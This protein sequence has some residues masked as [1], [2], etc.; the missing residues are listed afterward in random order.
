[1]EALV[2]H[3]QYYYNPWLLSVLYGRLFFQDQLMT[4]YQWLNPQYKVD[5]SLLL[6]ETR[7][8]QLIDELC[9]LQQSLQE[10]LYPFDWGQLNFEYVV[11][12]LATLFRPSDLY[13]H[14]HCGDVGQLYACE[15]VL[16]LS[17]PNQSESQLVFDAII[18]Y[19]KLYHLPGSMS[20]SGRL[21]ALLLN[22]KYCM[23]TRIIGQQED[24]V[25]CY[26]RALLMTMMYHVLLDDLMSET[27]R[28]QTQLVYELGDT[29][30][31]LCRLSNLLRVLQLLCQICHQ[32][33]E[34][35]FKGYAVQAEPQARARG[36]EGNCDCNRQYTLQHNPEPTQQQ[37][38]GDEDWYFIDCETGH[39]H[40]LQLYKHKQHYVRIARQFA[41]DCT[42]RRLHGRDECAPSR[43]KPTHGSEISQ[44]CH[45]CRH[46]EQNPTLRLFYSE[47]E[48]YHCL[49]LELRTVPLSAEQRL[50]HVL[51]P[52]QLAPITSLKSLICKTL[53]ELQH[54]FINSGFTIR[55]CSSIVTQCL[56]DDQDNSKK[57]IQLFQLINLVQLHEQIQHSLQGRQLDCE[58]DC[59]IRACHHGGVQ[60]PTR[61]QCELA[62]RIVLL[63]HVQ[64]GMDNQ[65]LT[66]ESFER[67]LLLS[68]VISEVL[69]QDLQVQMAQIYMTFR[70]VL[71]QWLDT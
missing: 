42:L 31:Q 45:V 69:Y 6:R 63:E 12:R 58:A 13:F 71:S 27:K 59:I 35:E 65:R 39:S 57:N 46:F 64:R 16:A 19:I 40:Y 20:Q 18:H 61:S 25:I 41:F 56:N 51:S 44:Q 30:Q 9:Q 68:N 26:N 70:Q 3:Q 43:C 2:K 38:T 60:R 32:Q 24:C 11:Y 53:C 36:H 17:L 29:R 48:H 49:Q 67:S 37:L 22:T 62:L 23:E 10:Q 54:L 15:S 5:A 66:R 14:T 47:V 7:A 8:E 4:L 34:D 33:Y 1:M 52:I 50:H 21:F 55:H 28:Q